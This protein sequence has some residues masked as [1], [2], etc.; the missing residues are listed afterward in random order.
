MTE[1]LRKSNNNYQA[2]S[3]GIGLFLG[4]S[5]IDKVVDGY[6][7]SE[8]YYFFSLT[9]INVDGDKR[10]IGL[11]ILGKVFISDKLKEKSAKIFNQ[12]KF[13]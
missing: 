1:E 12:R 13:K 9:K 10:T 2:T 7:D 3:A 11:G 6:I 8:N 5:L 4:S